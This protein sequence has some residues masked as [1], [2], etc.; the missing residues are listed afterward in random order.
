MSARSTATAQAI[1]KALGRGIRFLPPRNA[2]RKPIA[3]ADAKLKAQFP[4][5]KPRS[6]TSLFGPIEQM[7][8]RSPP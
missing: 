1:L 5:R 7:G 6:V 8:E 2:D 4:P 3:L